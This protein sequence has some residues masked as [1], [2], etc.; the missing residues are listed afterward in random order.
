MKLVIIPVDGAVYVDGVSYSS[1]NL[2]MCPSN[3]HALQWKDTAGWVEFVDNIDG[4]K[5]Q[6]QTITELP[7]WALEAKNIWDSAKA[8]EE[9]AKAAQQATQAE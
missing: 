5:P 6:N 2:S 7:S 8:A 9:A 3:V 4:T 1:L